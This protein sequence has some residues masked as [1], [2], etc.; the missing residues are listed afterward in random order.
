MNRRDFIQNIAISPA[1]GLRLD[2]NKILKPK[3]LKA[4]DTIGLV[5]PAAPAYSKETVEVVA[6][7]MQALGFK[8]KYGKN[9]WKRYGY[10][11]GNDAERAADINEMFADSNVK[12]I[13]CVHGGWGCARILP[14]LNYQMIKNNPKVIV[15][16][17][18]VTA[19]L[20]GIHAQTGLVTFHGPVGGSTWNDFSVKYFKSVLMNAEK[21]KYENPINKGDNLTQVEDRIST[22]NRGIA[23]GKLIGGNLTVLCH[24]LGSKFVPNFKNAIVFCEDVQ[25]QPYSVDRMIN[26][27][28]L[29]GVFEEMN[30]FVFGKCTKCE[31]G[32]GSYGSLTLEDLWED[33][34]K[35]TKKPAFVG[36]MIGH[37]NNKFTIP[38]GIEAEINADQ[39]IIQFLESSVE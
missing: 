11:A 38:I 21:V 27:M 12:A 25:E 32:E 9:I 20:L 26:H 17:S 18:D 14:L 39:G 2:D 15:G 37:I 6:E 23:K 30:G 35:P 3:R 7:S 1:L 10:L 29:C 16:Y 4:G 28:K 24:I 33:H 34:I 13:L 8:V 31:P 36:S 22:I 5:C 19:L